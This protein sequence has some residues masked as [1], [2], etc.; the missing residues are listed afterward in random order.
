MCN[1]SA[2]MAASLLPGGHAFFFTFPTK[3]RSEADSLL[4]ITNR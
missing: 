1:A 2:G 4:K 3:K